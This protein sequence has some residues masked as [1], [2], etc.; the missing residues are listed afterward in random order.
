MHPNLVKQ[1]DPS[2]RCPLRAASS[3]IGTSLRAGAMTRIGTH[4]DGV[5]SGQ[6]NAKRKKSN[7]L[8]VIYFD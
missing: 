8:F 1:E 5:A 4:C 6:K 7:E 3:R 2:V